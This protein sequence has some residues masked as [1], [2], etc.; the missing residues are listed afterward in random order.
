MCV[1]VCMYVYV[2]IYVCVCMY[3][4]IKLTQDMQSIT[5]SVLTNTLFFRFIFCHQLSQVLY[6]SRRYQTLYVCICI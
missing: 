4:Y 1:C 5:F 3:I 6:Q 2:C